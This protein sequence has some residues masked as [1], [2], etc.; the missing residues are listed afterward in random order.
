[1]EGVYSSLNP[2]INDGE[3]IYYFKTGQIK[4]ITNYVNDKPT[5]LT[6]FYKEDGTLDLECA[7]TLEM[8]DNSDEINKAVANFISFVNRKIKYPEYSRKAGIEG[9]AI[10]AFYIDKDGLPF[11]IK[12]SKTVNNELDNEAIRIINLY[13]WPSPTYKGDKT[14]LLVALPVTFMLK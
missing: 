3:L 12:V 10:V 1:M 2:D 8:L 11:R 9:Q 4:E 5:T 13:K 7:S 6:K 14:L